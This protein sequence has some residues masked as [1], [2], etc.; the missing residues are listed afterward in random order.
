MIKFY[1]HIIFRVSTEFIFYCILYAN[2]SAS[3]ASGNAE[4][5]YQRLRS[6]RDAA[7]V[8]FTKTEQSKAEK[9]SELAKSL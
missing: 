9:R 7:M 3:F 5:K 2:Q 4:F 1:E 8:L 6:E